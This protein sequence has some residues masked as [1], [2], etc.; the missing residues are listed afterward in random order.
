MSETSRFDISY[1]EHGPTVDYH[2]C[3]EWDDDG[4][5]YGTREDH[6]F[7]FEEAKQAMIEWHRSEAD[8][9]AKMTLKEWSGE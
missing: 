5:C 4:G 3:R 7:S 8:R 9:W 2:F 1:R 6:G